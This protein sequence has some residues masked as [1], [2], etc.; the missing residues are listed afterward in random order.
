MGT[1]TAVRLTA[2]EFAAL[3]DDSEEKVELIDGE[4]CEMASGGPVHETVKGNFS[5][6]LAAF[7]KTH[8]LN[9]RFQPE[10]RFYLSNRETFQPDISIVLSSS[11]DPTGKGRITLIPDLA[12]EIVSS[13]TAQGLQHKINVLLDF[14]AKAVMAVYPEDRM[15]FIH[16]S[17]GIERILPS[18]T[19]RLED[20]LPGFAVAASVIFEGL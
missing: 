11:L 15:I 20:V 19:L 6:E 18:G 10:T 5:I 13:E 4:V 8:K 7:I 14:G 1:A 16:R 9:A 3:P 17:D 2:D 12:I